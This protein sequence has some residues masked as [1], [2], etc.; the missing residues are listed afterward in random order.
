[1]KIT[2]RKEK[3]PSQYI[4]CFYFKGGREV[5][6]ENQQWGVIGW[7]RPHIPALGV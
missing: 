3:I 6:E 2:Y 7:Q 1:M 5:G 4:P